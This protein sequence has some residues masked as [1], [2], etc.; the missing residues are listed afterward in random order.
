[1]RAVVPS[2]M[3]SVM[4]AMEAYGAASVLDV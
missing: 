3:S 1:M 2:L 4:P